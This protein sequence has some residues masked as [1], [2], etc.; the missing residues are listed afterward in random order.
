MHG[1]DDV[2]QG[3]ETEDKL[4]TVNSEESEN[5]SEVPESVQMFD[6]DTLNQPRPKRKR[7]QHEKSQHRNNRRAEKGRGSRQADRKGRSA[8]CTTTTP[9]LIMPDR[10]RSASEAWSQEESEP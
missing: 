5:R 8:P 6:L 4:E 1:G 2:I 10:S 3:E 7:R 9:K